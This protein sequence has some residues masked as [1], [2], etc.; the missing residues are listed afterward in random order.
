MLTKAQIQ[1]F[2]DDGYLVVP[3]MYEAE[4]VDK[5]SLWSDEILAWE[6]QAGRHMVYYEDSV[7]AGAGKVV[8]R[9]ENFCP[10]H[11]NFDQLMREGLLVDTVSQLLGE[12][13][14]LFKEKINMKMPGGDGFKPHQ[15]AQAGWNHY[16]GFYITA[17]VSVDPATVENGCLE[18]VKGW[19]DKGLVGDEWRPLDDTDMDGMAFAPCPTAPGDVVFFDSYAPHQS[20]PNLTD[21]RRR[22]LYVTYN[23]L[24]EGDHRAQYYADKRLSFPPDIERT[25]DKEYVFRV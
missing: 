11:K 6:E 7:I 16:A 15:D 18:M 14:V 5:I 24:S 8:S 17:L 3:G 21:Q 9:V 19:H 23:R 4:M 22:V 13:A 2:L 25:P 12:N 1:S 10:Y 20:A